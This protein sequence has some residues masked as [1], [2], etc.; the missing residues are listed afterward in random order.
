[1]IVPRERLAEVEQIAR[2]AASEIV[3][4]DPRDEKTT[5]GPVANRAQFERVQQMIEIG[6]REGARPLCG[7][8]GRPD[9][10]ERGFFA[11]PTIFSG[12]QPDM[13]IARE[14]IFGPVLA[15]IPYDSVEEAI[16]I[17]N[18]SVYG[19]GAHVHGTDI[20]TARAVAARLRS[21]QVHINSP[22]WD[23][24][25][26]FGGYKRSGNGREYGVEGLEEYLETKA[27]LGF[28]QA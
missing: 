4:G 12:V 20:E 21:G 19:L 25:A 5:H 7:G 2:S 1:M 16:E 24:N 8:P 17:A 28:A 6:L 14:E 26:P 10:L 3:V 11:Q 18:D 13:T 27:V 23:P 9:G 15:I 22:A